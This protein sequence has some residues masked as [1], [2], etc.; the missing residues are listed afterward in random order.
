MVLQRGECNVTSAFLG[1]AAAAGGPSACATGGG[2]TDQTSR[3]VVDGT[4]TGYAKPSW[5][6]GIFGNPADGVRDIP[7]VTLFAANGIWGHY[8]TVCYSDTA[9]GGTSCAGSPSG[10]AGFGGTS[11]A[12]PMMAAIQA[13]V[14]EKWSLTKVGNP[15]P[16][17]YSIAKSEFGSDGNSACYSIN[18][19]PR[20]G[21]VSAC[22]F[23]D[24]TQGD[25]DI[26]CKY[27]GTG[28]VGCYLPSGTYGSLSTQA[29]SSPGTVTAGGSGY[30]GAP[31]C[32]LG[33]PSNSGSY[34]SPGARPCGEVELKL[35]APQRYLAE[36]SPPS[37]SPTLARDT[38]AAPVARSQAVEDRA[39]LAPPRPR[40]P[41]PL[42]RGNPLTAP[43][44]AGTSP[45]V[46]AA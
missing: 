43:R 23:Y 24:I 33:A 32:S 30:T 26:D 31:S 2:G 5:Q 14:N 45:P 44:Q 34:Q 1:T 37:L 29:L 17:Y 4:C 3:A 7:D 6:S 42:L 20:E 25:N 41:Q 11:V 46:S 35:P 12:A 40:S 21:L 19:P 22:T 27:N 38:S 10:W 39:L 28:K 8:V 18:Q 36:L 9:N 13:L 15:A 16:T